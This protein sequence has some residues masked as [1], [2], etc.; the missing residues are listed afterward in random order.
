MGAVRKA[1][2]R[3]EK[4]RSSVVIGYTRV[5]TIGQLDNTSLEMQKRKIKEFC[6][7]HGYT[8]A[9]IIEDVESGTKAERDGYATLLTKLKTNGFDG[10]VS[11]AFDRLFRGVVPMAELLNVLDK[12]GKFIHTIEGQDTRTEWGRMLGEMLGL[13]AGWEAKRI[14]S[15]M[16]GGRLANFQK[17]GK[18]GG[19]GKGT[20]GLAPFG[21]E[22]LG[23]ELVDVPE[24]Q[25]LVKQIFKL[26]LIG[27][28]NS[29]LAKFLNEFS[30]TRAGKKWT[31]QSV[32][33]LL[34]NPFY[35]G[36]VAYGEWEFPQ[37]HKPLIS[38]RTWNKVQNRLRIIPGERRRVIRIPKGQYSRVTEAFRKAVVQK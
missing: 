33:Y 27:W 23:G 19:E 3:A 12:R 7:L 38:V 31:R 24:Q 15:R 13:V 37:H 16:R 14:T 29:V 25:E 11:L 9:E 35:K 17:Y 10:V 4:K 20:T 36:V 28:N 2:K 34:K 21:Y 22:Y 18:S 32:A 6:K 26:C 8:L 30:T 5:S 1:Q